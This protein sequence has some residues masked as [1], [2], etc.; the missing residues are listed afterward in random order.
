MA[1]GGSIYVDGRRKTKKAGPQLHLKD[2]PA[3][4]H[5]VRVEKQGFMDFYAIV[6][7]PYL[8]TT[9]LEVHMRPG[10]TSAK[11]G[12]TAAKKQTVEQEAWYEKWWVWTIVGG[13]VVTATVTGVILAQ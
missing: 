13:V 3:G 5:A 12:F 8:S 1:K 10:T 7:I 6:Q 2:I 11:T 9:K 4:Q